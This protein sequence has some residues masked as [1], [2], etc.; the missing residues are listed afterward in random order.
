MGTL[1]AIFTSSAVIGGVVSLVQLVLTRKDKT[2]ER[3]D[4]ID[5]KL[6][7]LAETIADNRAQRNRDKADDA[8]RRILAAS[9]EI[10][11]C[12]PHSKEWW[13]QT[14]DDVTEYNN[15]CAEHPAYRNNKAVHAIDSLDKEYA[16][17]LEINDFL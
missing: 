12:V 17:K 7:K 14:M 2:A 13:D 4:S 3:F 8:R 6:D 16:K 11:H 10:L 5:T 1:A 9:D 15:Y